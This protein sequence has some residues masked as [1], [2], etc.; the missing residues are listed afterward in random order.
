MSDHSHAPSPASNAS[1]HNHFEVSHW[2]SRLVFGGALLSAGIV[3]AP[4]VLPAIGIGSAEVAEE[5]MFVLH[6][7][8][9]TGGTGL[10]GFLNRGIAQLPLVGSSLAAG[11]LATAL[12]SGGIGF[13]GLLLSHLLEKREPQGTRFHWSKVIRY[14][15]L[16]TSALIAMPALLTGLSVG[17]SFLAT[18]TGNYEFIL[19][20]VGL[21]SKTLGVAG[22][23][24]AMTELSGLAAVAP[25]F[26]TCGAGLI[27][28]VLALFFGGRNKDKKHSMSNMDIRV[29]TSLAHPACA[30]IPCPV[31]LRLTHAD[32][33]PV[34]TAEIATTHTQKLHF[35][36]VD[37]SLQD[38][39][40]L[41][42]QP[43]A[44]AGVFSCSF[45]PRTNHSY[46]GWLDFATQQGQQ[47]HQLPVTLSH[48]A[49]KTNPSAIF[50][51]KKFALEGLHFE[52]EAPTL[53]Q[54]RDTTVNL[55]I[56]DANGQSVCDLEPVM[57]A[58][59]HLVGFSGDGKGMIHCHPMGEEPSHPDAR[60]Q[61]PLSFHIQPDTAGLTQFHL[62]IRHQGR[63]IFVPFGQ[64]IYPAKRTLEIQPLLAHRHH[65]SM[66]LV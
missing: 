57:G 17:V 58:Y 66:S 47:P 8:I 53:Q 39:H 11:G 4:Y 40:H 36:V 63:D 18:L 12:T 10:A 6:G 56:T 35:L 23:M 50:Q 37:D 9:D 14:A 43:T 25:H 61:S 44:Q 48:S 3:L 30:G 41:H 46:S 26:F 16:A 65:A 19:S 5:T 54:G 55:H 32:G 42:P 29:E 49:F 15:A 59:A 1:P 2:L 28:S 52:W 24:G 27:P 31:E 20:T 64:R 60:G 33:T 62:Q 34:N 21:M 13:G 7:C 51:N 38:Y 22:G 45:T